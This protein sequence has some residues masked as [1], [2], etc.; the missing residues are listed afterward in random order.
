MKSFADLPV[1]SSTALSAFVNEHGFELGDWP[2]A[3]LPP[4]HVKACMAYHD[5]LVEDY[6]RCPIPKDPAERRKALELERHRLLVPHPMLRTAWG[7]ITADSHYIPGVQLCRSF[8]INVPGFSVEHESM[9]GF[10]REMFQ[11]EVRLA[12]KRQLK[13][14]L[15]NAVL[16][17]EVCSSIGDAVVS[18]LVVAKGTRPQHAVEAD[19]TIGALLAQACKPGE[20]ESHLVRAR[21]AAD[22]MLS[23]TSTLH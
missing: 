2:L 14:W 23:L 10:D 5:M 7:Y 9:S 11:K 13:K 3:S 20:I 19:R 12:F 22:Q 17:H 6:E 15:H 4:S 1:L 21:L 18:V 8:Q 16:P